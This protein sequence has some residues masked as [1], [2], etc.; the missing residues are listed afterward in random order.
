MST[1]CQEVSFCEARKEQDRGTHKLH[2]DGVVKCP[3]DKVR[4]AVSKGKLRNQR[5]HNVSN[6]LRLYNLK[7]V[8]RELAH[9][10]Y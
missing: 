6:S 3:G 10:G 2:S 1:S 7:F 8:Q 5:Q 4:E 9:T